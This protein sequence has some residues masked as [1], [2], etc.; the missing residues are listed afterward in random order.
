MAAAAMALTPHYEPLRLGSAMPGAGMRVM[1]GHD[2]ST[3]SHA[4]D[5]R[6]GLA[7]AQPV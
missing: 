6:Q 7:Y 2:G 4:G 3:I 5:D 1:V